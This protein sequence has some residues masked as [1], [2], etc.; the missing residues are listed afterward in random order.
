MYVYNVHL[1]RKHILIVTAQIIYTAV[2]IS[3]DMQNNDFLTT[4]KT[5][6][7]L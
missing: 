6:A 1:Q 2:R 4:G 5:A 7:N 3:F